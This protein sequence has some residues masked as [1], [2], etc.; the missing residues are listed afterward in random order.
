MFISPFKSIFHKNGVRRPS[1][2]RTFFYLYIYYKILLR[3]LNPKQK[4]LFFIG[5]GNGRKDYI[6]NRC[7]LRR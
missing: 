3:I 1:V 2:N 5:I 6:V 7:K 4:T